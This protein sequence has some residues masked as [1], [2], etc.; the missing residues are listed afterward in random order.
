MSVLRWKFLEK[1][2]AL[3]LQ[4]I[5]VVATDSAMTAFG[6]LQGQMNARP[7]I[8]VGSSTPLAA[9][10]IVTDTLQTAAN[11]TLTITFPKAF[12]AGTVPRVTLTA[13]ASLTTQPTV[14]ELSAT[15]TATQCVVKTYRT[16]T[17]GVLIG[18]TIDPVQAQQAYVTY[19][20]IGESP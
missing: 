11:G 17:Q 2:T 13:L 4:N 12:K 1:L 5:A 14:A 20:A 19:L 3:S 18:G 7:M 6:K 16:K 8:Y 9:P 10:Q 15:P